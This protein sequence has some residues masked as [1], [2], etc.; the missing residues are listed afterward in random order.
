M[1]GVGVRIVYSLKKIQVFY[2]KNYSIGLLWKRYACGTADRVDLAR[3]GV[4]VAWD[5]SIRIDVK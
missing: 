4:I 1:G 2:D 5:G 3:V